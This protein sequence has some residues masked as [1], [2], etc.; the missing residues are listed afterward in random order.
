MINS[1]V[2]LYLPCPFPLA[3]V[4]GQK[5]I[6]KFSPT[7]NHSLSPSSRSSP[8]PSSSISPR[9]SP[10]SCL[11]FTLG[12]SP[13]PHLSHSPSHIFYVSPSHNPSSGKASNYNQAPS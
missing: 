5:S 13:N 4:N 12:P 6:F 7:P 8:T 1:Y 2:N 10:S 11:C 3:S 9:L